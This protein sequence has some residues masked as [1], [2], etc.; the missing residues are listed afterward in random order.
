MKT[1]IPTT[2]RA[3]MT[4][5]P[6]T[7]GPQVSLAEAHTIMREREVRHLPV[8]QGGR[9]IGMVTARDLALVEALADFDPKEISVD[10]A[11]SE[12]VYAV[13]PDAPLRMVTAE[14]ADRKL[15]SAVIVE[16]GRVVGVFT[17]T[18][19]CRALTQMLSL[20]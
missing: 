11:M 14:M 13:S 5:S 18:D 20:A 8:M 10:E 15:G 6:M 16:A 12:D 17:V 4:E 9:L 2:V 3:Y 1:N 7:V 19:A